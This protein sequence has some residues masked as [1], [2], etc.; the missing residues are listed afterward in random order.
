[1][2]PSGKELEMKKSRYTDEQIAFAL[3]TRKDFWRTVKRVAWAK[4]PRLVRGMSSL[5]ITV[6]CF[7]A[8]LV[9]MIV[10]GRRRNRID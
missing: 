9:A 8:V 6:A 10:S 2:K 3:S 1:V 4:G 7:G 5:M